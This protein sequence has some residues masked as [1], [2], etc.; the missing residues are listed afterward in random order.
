MFNIF[1]RNK[2]TLLN[3][4]WEILKS[5]IKISTTPKIYE[6]IYITDENKYYSV[7]NVIHNIKGGKC[8]NI[9][10]ILEEYIDDYNLFEK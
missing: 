4:K 8:N 9:F 7:C 5:D 10:V 6:L 1:K 2:I 3:N